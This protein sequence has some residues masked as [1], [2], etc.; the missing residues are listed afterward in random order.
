MAFEELKKYL[1]FLQLLTR[2]TQ[3]DILFLYLRVSQSVVNVV[4]VKK[5]KKGKHR[6]IYYISKVFKEAKVKHSTTKKFAFI[7]IVARKMKPCF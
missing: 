5:E 1:G 7:V 4:M 6:P 3:K 2:P